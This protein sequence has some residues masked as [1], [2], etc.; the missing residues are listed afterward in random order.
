MQEGGCRREFICSDSRAAL[1]VLPS[2]TV[3]L[4]HILKCNN[5]LHNLT[6]ERFVELLRIPKHSGRR[7][8]EITDHLVRAKVWQPEQAVCISYT[9]TKKKHLDLLTGHIEVNHHK[10]KTEPADCPDCRFC[11]V[12]KETTRHILC[13]CKALAH[14]F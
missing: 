5:T 11:E 4:K 12:E 2:M 14:E 7:C 8:N 13:D 6:K 10:H 1:K 3:K 9:Q